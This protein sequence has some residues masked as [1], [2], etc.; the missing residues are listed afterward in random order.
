MGYS[1]PGWP[2]SLPDSLTS[3]LLWET[4]TG[5]W[6]KERSLADWAVPTAILPRESQQPKDTTH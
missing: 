3:S 2:K 4:H 5:L 6:L 1:L